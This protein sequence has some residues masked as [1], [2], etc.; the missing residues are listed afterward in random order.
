MRLAN[1]PPRTW[2]DA[3]YRA[4]P[5]FFS[6][7]GRK[8]AFGFCRSPVPDGRREFRV[9]NSSTRSRY[10]HIHLRPCTCPISRA[11]TLD[12]VI[13]RSISVVITR[14]FC[15]LH[16]NELDA[17]N[18]WIDQ[19]IRS[20]RATKPCAIG[21]RNDSTHARGQR[22]RPPRDERSYAIRSVRTRRIMRPVTRGRKFY[23]TISRGREAPIATRHTRKDRQWR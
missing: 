18:E 10:L 11:L 13:Y 7:Y 15:A 23:V 6:S 9:C 16:R 22:R 12:S 8:H 20:V 1:A 19:P 21:I 3:I 5:V 2:I 14:C 4:I 17:N